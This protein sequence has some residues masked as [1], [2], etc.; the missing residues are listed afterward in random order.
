MWSLP[1]SHL[2]RW[3]GDF[4]LVAS[5]ACVNA[6]SS[7]SALTFKPCDSLRNAWKNEGETLRLLALS[8]M[9]TISTSSARAPPT[10]RLT[11]SIPALNATSR[12]IIGPNAD[13]RGG[14]AA[15]IAA[16]AGGAM[17][18]AALIFSFTNS[19]AM[20]S[21]AEL[22][23]LVASLIPFLKSSRL[24]LT[25]I[26]SAG[27]FGSYKKSRQHAD[28]DQGARGDRLAANMSIQQR[29]CFWRR[30]PAANKPHLNHAL[31]ILYSLNALIKSYKTSPWLPPS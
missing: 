11:R 2:L 17:T 28:R 18:F 1:V 6:P 15:P 24:T 25:G 21:A 7:S 30:G 26:I 14:N 3:I 12:A 29:G 20:N 23:E 4:S 22:T 5:N 27:I 9:A 19:F 13:I 31:T 10:A 16:S 8:A